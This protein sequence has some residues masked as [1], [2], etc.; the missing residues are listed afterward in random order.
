MA[1]RVKGRPAS[2]KV[3]VI[4]WRAGGLGFSIDDRN[5]S[6]GMHA[7]LTKSHSDCSEI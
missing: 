3:L 7:P 2:A 4:A 1:L 5:N 6:S